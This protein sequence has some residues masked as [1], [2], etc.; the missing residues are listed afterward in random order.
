MS[1]PLVN[2]R[3]GSLWPLKKPPA[4]KLSLI[5]SGDLTQVGRIHG[6]SEEASRLQRARSLPVK[7]RYHPGLSA[8]AVSQRQCKG[9]SPRV[10][11][12]PVLNGTTEAC[13]WQPGV[14]ACV[15]FFTN[16]PVCAAVSCETLNIEQAEQDVK[17]WSIPSS[18]NVLSAPALSITASGSDGLTAPLLPEHRFVRVTSHLNYPADF[19]K[20]IKGLIER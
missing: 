7:Y 15:A 6:V 9:P 18:L 13:A 20:H 14:L 12:G 1:I 16:D 8:N 11:A 3:T 4:L 17:G 10:F 19:H 5:C 2:N